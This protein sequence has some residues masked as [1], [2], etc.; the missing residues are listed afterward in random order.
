MTLV[1]T[2]EVS[3]NFFLFF[4]ERNL[5]QVTRSTSLVKIS[6]HF[7]F[8]LLIL[9]TSIFIHAYVTDQKLSGFEILVNIGFFLFQ[10]KYLLHSQYVRYLQ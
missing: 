8:D 9:S 5:L 3:F 6:E 7:W 1:V 10:S 2:S 4:V